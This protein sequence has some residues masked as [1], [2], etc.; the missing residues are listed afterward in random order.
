MLRTGRLLLGVSSMLPRTGWHYVVNPPLHRRA[1]GVAGTDV[2]DRR[3]RRPAGS[4]LGR[5]GATAA[6]AAVISHGL[7]AT[8]AEIDQIQSTRDAGDDELP[9]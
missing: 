7:L 2:S 4:T 1:S 9:R 5:L 6:A 3:H 8:C